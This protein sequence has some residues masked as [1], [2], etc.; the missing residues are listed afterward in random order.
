MT[1]K[2]NGSKTVANGKFDATAELLDGD[3]DVRSASKQTMGLPVDTGWS[4]VVLLA[5]IIIA[6]IHCG[7]LRSSGLFFIEFILEFQADVSEAALVGALQNAVFAICAL[8]VLMFGLKVFSERQLAFVGFS[9]A[10]SGYA[11]SSLA[12]NFKFLIFFLGVM[13]GA[14]MSMGFSPVFI[15]VGKHFDKRRGLANGLMLSGACLGSLLMPPLIR[16]FLDEFGLRGALL[17]TAGI[18]ANILPF[19]LLLRPESFYRRKG[20]CFH[21]HQIKNNGNNLK[22]E[23]AISL[24]EEKQEKSDI[25]GEFVTK[26]ETDIMKSSKPINRKRNNTVSE[27]TDL[28][29]ATRRKFLSNSSLVMSTSLS[30]VVWG[31]YSLAIAE[32]DTKRGAL[33]TLKKMCDLSILKRLEYLCFL[34]Y[35]SLACV[36]GS[37]GFVFIPA[38]AKDMNLTNSEIVLMLGVM[39]GA[40]FV[41]RVSSGYLTDLPSFRMTHILLVTQIVIAV[42]ANSARF[43]STYWHFYIFAVVY[44]MFSGVPF[45]MQASLVSRIVGLEFFP[46]GFAIMMMLHQGVLSGS[47]P[48][49]GYLRDVTGTYHATFHY[50]GICSCVAVLFLFLEP[51]SRK[52]DERKAKPL[53]T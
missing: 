13:V 50:L 17:M 25:L 51:L 27:G 29:M 28:K 40:D 2:D 38:Y 26:S 11:I 5:S 24:G 42:T 36:P 33:Q 53:H 37:I 41:G 20:A 34:V 43:L 3:N 22:K 48:V 8:P 49:L 19:I 35:Y 16:F 15:S 47:A 30:D 39:A 18:Y 1:T 7:I 9:F 4:W 23:I 10:S 12:P 21:D 14:G 45:S 31:S 32:K 52:R 44:G 46:T 6:T